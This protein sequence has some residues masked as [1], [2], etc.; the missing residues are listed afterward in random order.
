MVANLETYEAIYMRKFLVGP[1]RQGMEHIIIHCDNQSCINLSENLV[2]HDR[3]NH[4]KI[5]Y[6]HLIYYV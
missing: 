1:F 6:H 4:I 5:R 3:S 2:F